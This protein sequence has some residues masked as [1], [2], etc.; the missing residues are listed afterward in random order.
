M[1]LYT[2]SFYIHLAL[3]AT[4]AVATLFSMWRKYKCLCHKNMLQT[5]TFLSSTR[6]HIF[7]F[8]RNCWSKTL[9]LFE[10]FSNFIFYILYIFLFF[11]CVIVAVSATNYVKYI[12]Q[13]CQSEL[14]KLKE[15][16]KNYRKQKKKHKKSRFNNNLPLFYRI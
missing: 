11:C 7:L 10:N 3:E 14:K 12:V 2:N 13:H 9:T 16:K 8:I 4:V 6:E 15:L 1:R 5:F